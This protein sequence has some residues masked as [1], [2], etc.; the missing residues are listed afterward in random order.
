MKL[1]LSVCTFRLRHYL[2]KF[3]SFRY[4]QCIT[5]IV[6]RVSIWIVWA[7]Q[8]V[9]LN[10][11]KN[12]QFPP[13]RIILQNDCLWALKPTTLYL[14]FFNVMQILTKYS[15]KWFMP[16]RRISVTCISFVTIYLHLQR[17]NIKASVVCK[18]QTTNTIL[19][20]SVHLC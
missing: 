12:H 9:N 5:Q 14:K 1:C 16:Q 8:T 4:F 3:E 10:N 18:Q 20:C 2:P 11:N 15:G 6:E 7:K 17:K 13:E 19:E